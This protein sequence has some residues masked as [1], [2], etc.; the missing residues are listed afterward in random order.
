LLFG[1]ANGVWGGLD[2]HQRHALT[3]AL[4]RGVTLGAVLDQALDNQALGNH[5]VGSQSAGM[6]AA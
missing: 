6:D 1:E 3:Q 5:R 2:R 4:R